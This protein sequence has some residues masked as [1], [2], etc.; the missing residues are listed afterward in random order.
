MQLPIQ[1]FD[2]LIKVYAGCQGSYN[3]AS[4]GKSMP[5][6]PINLILAHKEHHMYN[7]NVYGRQKL[8]S[9]SNVHYHANLS[10]PCQVDSNVVEAPDDIK[11]T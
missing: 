6:P 11:A 9:P 10:Y 5:P 7:N 2:L 4:D 1:I 8:S 3:H